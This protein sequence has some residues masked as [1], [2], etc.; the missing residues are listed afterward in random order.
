MSVARSLTAHRPQAKA[1]GRIIA[2]V[3]YATVIKHQNL[4]ATPLEKQLSVVGTHKRFTQ[5]GKA[6]IQINFGLEGTKCLTF[7]GC[8]G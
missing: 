5:Q 6:L 7:Y 8:H 3:L 4:G 2:G 1:L